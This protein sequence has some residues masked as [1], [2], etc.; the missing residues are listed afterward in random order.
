MHCRIWVFTQKFP[1]IRELVLGRGTQKIVA[2][3]G[4]IVS[5]ALLLESNRRSIL[6]DLHQEKS[7]PNDF[8]MSIEVNFL[9]GPSYYLLL[10]G[11]II[12]FVLAPALLKSR[13]TTFYQF[14]TKNGSDWITG[15][16]QSF[17]YFCCFEATA[18]RCFKATGQVKHLPLIRF[19]RDQLITSF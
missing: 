4:R 17:N 6:L 12:K 1:L 2:T 7:F 18:P 11:N 19:E 10:S 16:N 8:S 5:S 9:L 14:T 13:N 3:R 15:L